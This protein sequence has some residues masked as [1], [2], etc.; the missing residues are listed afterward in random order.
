ME[1]ES[2]T[3]IVVDNMKKVRLAKRMTQEEVAKRAS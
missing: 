1:R 3:Q 2:A